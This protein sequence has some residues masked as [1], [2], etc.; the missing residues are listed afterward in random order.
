MTTAMAAALVAAGVV[1]PS[2]SSSAPVPKKKN[3]K[4]GRNQRK[5]NTAR[6]EQKTLITWEHEIGT[7][8][9]SVQTFKLGY[10]HH[11]RGVYWAQI[12]IGNH[13]P[14]EIVV[15]FASNLA[16]GVIPFYAKGGEVVD[17]GDVPIPMLRVP[18]QWKPIKGQM[19]PHTRQRDMDNADLHLRLPDGQ[20][21]DLQVAVLS[22]SGNFFLSI[23]E[24]A[25]GQVIKLPAEI[26]EQD[27]GYEKVVT[28]KGAFVV[29]PL[30][31]E[32]NYPG[33][34]F[35][36]NVAPRSGP[37]LVKMAARDGAFIE[38][39]EFDEPLWERPP[40]PSKPG[41][42]VGGIVMWYNPI[43]GGRVICAD[44]VECYV[45]REAIRN[46]HGK[47]AMKEGDFPVLAPLQP[48]LLRY[49][50]GARGRVVKDLE[51]TEPECDEE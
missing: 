50:D 51:V 1:P 28:D 8:N 46:R 47:S 35:L 40:F 11:V 31:P 27:V 12:M 7:I 33:A 43:V 44:G 6:S 22:F 21:I 29:L 48:V 24:I 38:T 39:E 2:S 32:H 41:W 25:S 10:T 9:F 3:G 37:E 5:W 49:E 34:S 42:Q 20:F 15:E 16:E 18:V 30:F 19:V 4:R 14:S 13:T 45:P 17:C 36:K 23:Q 26:A